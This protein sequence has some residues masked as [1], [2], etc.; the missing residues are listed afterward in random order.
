MQLTT[1]EV[2]SIFAGVIATV[3]GI[4]WG[5]VKYILSSAEIR[6]NEE[7]EALAKKSKEEN[8][9]IMNELKVMNE[10]IHKNN[11][12]MQRFLFFID[13]MKELKTD[14]NTMLKEMKGLLHKHDI[15]IIRLQK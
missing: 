7:I 5:L 1:F 11:N 15:D 6:I 14:T 3:S 2:I 13:E 9:K 12:D 4:I 8:D 10:Q